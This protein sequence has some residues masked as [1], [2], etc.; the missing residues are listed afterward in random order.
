MELILGA[1][2]EARRRD[3]DYVIVDLLQRAAEPLMELGRD[4]EADRFL[5]EALA[6]SRTVSIGPLATR[7]VGMRSM[8]DIAL[9][10]PAAAMG[11]ASEVIRMSREGQSDPMFEYLAVRTLAAARALVCNQAGSGELD[12]AATALFADVG[13]GAD[14]MWTGPLRA[15]LEPARESAEHRAA[16]VLGGAVPRQVVDRW[17]EAVSR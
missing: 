1:L 9:G 4:D 16:A 12:G 15:V 17:L 13:I 14:K 8:A 5:D 3:D 11:H 10:R 2:V 7:L 6:L